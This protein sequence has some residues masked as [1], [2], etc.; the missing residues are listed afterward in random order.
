MSMAE[1]IDLNKIDLPDCQACTAPSK[2]ILACTMDV[3][4]PGMPGALYFCENRSCRAKWNEIA[5]Y[6]MRMEA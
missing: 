6:I 3:E 1:I 5:K 2:R 4:G